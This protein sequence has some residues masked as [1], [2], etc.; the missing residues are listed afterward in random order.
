[1]TFK[2]AVQKMLEG[3]KRRVE[4]IDDIKEVRR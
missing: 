1:M 3:K 4:W 2:E